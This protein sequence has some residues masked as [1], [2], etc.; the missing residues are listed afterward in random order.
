MDDFSGLK[1]WE[2]FWGDGGEKC[3]RSVGDS[4]KDEDAVEVSFEGLG[5]GLEGIGI[6]MAEISDD[7]WRAVN[8][9]DFGE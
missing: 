6:G 8:R 7:R 2:E 9:F 4:C 1:F 5:D 3:D